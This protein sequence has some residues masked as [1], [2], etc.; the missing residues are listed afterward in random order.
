VKPCAILALTLILPGVLA[1]LPA[2]AFPAGAPQPDDPLVPSRGDPL[3]A[4]PVDPRALSSEDP[5]GPFLRGLADS[6]DAFF[7]RT[8][9]AFDTTGVDSL[10]EARGAEKP[11]KPAR[12]GASAHFFPVLGYHRATGATLGAGARVG[13]DDRGWMEARGSY[14]FANK[15]GRYRTSLA[16][17]L[18][19]RGS[20]DARSR[21]VL[22]G[23]YARETLPF[24][25]EH[26]GPL[27]SALVALSTGRDWQSVF[28]RRGA[29]AALRW[30]A[31]SSLGEVGWRIARDQSMPLATRFSLWGADRDVPPVT[32]ACGGAFREGFLEI[33]HAR[34]GSTHLGAEAGYAARHRWRARV[35]GAHRIGF[36]GFVA[37]LQAEAGL[38]AHR[39]PAQDRF[40]VGGPAAGHS[41]EQDD[42]AGNRL[43]LG[44]IELIHGVDLLR[45]LRVPH[46]SFFVL[47]P[48]VF[49]HEG[50]AWIG[51]DGSWNGPPSKSRRG[52]AGV[53]LVHLP[54]I[55]NPATFVRLQ[56]AWPLQRRSGAARFSFAVGRWHD[57]APIK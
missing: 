13:D 57:L 44:K 17:V 39:G 24:A 34:Q 28:E 40:E 32:P 11:T 2:F 12:S 42:D 4:S 22:T 27:G 26:A 23:S 55:P 7:G 51:E 19:R 15:E 1:S 37:N 10:I 14:G 56:M 46:P 6:T 41:L 9:V 52:A 36:A 50:A 47:H 30:E 33:A 54:G 20:D 21:L 18:L 16:R 25:P 43:V 53:V 8:A 31:T 48:G 45:A 49:V 5:L 38:A 3:A 29:E 35:A